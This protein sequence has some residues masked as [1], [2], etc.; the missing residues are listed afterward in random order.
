[1]EPQACGAQDDTDWVW[2][3]LSLFAK[4]GYHSSFGLAALRMTRVGV[5][6]WFPAF[7]WRELA[8]EGR[9][10]A[11]LAAFEAALEPLGALGA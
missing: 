8:V 6:S 11:Y 10:A 5:G 7:S 1:M 9:A 2:F 4:C 3:A